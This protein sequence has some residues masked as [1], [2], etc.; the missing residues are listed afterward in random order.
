MKKFT[1]TY[2]EIITIPNLLFAWEEFLLG[3]KKRVDVAIFQDHLMNNIFSL[4]RELKTK[5]YQHG[6][7]QAFKISDPKP[8]DIHKATVSDRLLHHLLY[9]E[10]YQYFDQQFIYDSYS[11]RLGKGTHR[12]VRR[13]S[14]FADKVSQ[15]KRR[16]VWIF[17]CD[18]R[19]FFDSVD[20]DILISI[21]RDKIRDEKLM[22]I[23]EKIIRS[24]STKPGKGIPLGN[25]TSQ[26]FSNIYLDR[27]DQFMKRNLRIKHYL[28]YTDDFIILDVKKERLEKLVPVLND[29]LEQDLKLQLHPNKLIIRKIHRGIDFLGY[30][31]YPTHLILRTK[32]K[33]RMLR[34]I[35]AKKRELDVGII[36]AETF[37]NTL[38]SYL[39]M[40]TH[41]RGEG[42]R[43]EVNR[44]TD[45]WGYLN[46][47]VEA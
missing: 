32:T 26:I 42:I 12:A 6:G 30:I 36:S 2:C 7:Y 44:I 37:D 18:I 15:N 5:K 20:H 9:Q 39:G 11:C 4:Y 25:L 40:L 24:Y 21:L 22:E 14:E 43:N 41:C 29:F 46:F 33:R 19:K 45:D 38:Q 47:I 8:R 10:T 16:T 27:L 1:K 35:A 23:I 3:K 34:K 31:V 28:R 17:K 13:L